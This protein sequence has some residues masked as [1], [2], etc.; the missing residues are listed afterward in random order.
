MRAPTAGGRW[1][2]LGTVALA[3][4]LVPATRAAPGSWRTTAP[5]YAVSEVTLRLV[6]HSR[7]VRFPGHRR[8]PRPITTD[9][10]YPAG[11]SP[12]TGTPQPFPLVVFGHGYNVTPDTYGPLLRDLA[13][14]GY[15]VAAPVF[16]LGNHNAPGGANEADLVN[17]PRDMSFVI[18]QLLRLTDRQRG[19][20]SGL[21]DPHAIAVAGQSDGGS[22]ALAVAYNRSFADRRVRA[23]LILSGARIP[24]LGGYALS[25]PGPTVLAVQGTADPLNAP[26]S[27]YHYFDLLRAPKFLLRLWGAGHLPPYTTNAT[28]RAIVTRVSVAFLDRY[29]KR[30]PG[31]ARRMSLAGNARGLATLTG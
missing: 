10:W 12:D 23:A 8:Q 22:T 16:P 25:A 6:D 26:I 29:L 30:D 13:R 3:V 17:Q 28:E 4:L 7:S 27:T 19:S 20:V 1:V 24:G 18:T 9:V 21:I 14:A 31:A 5:S 11:G 2:V 15:V